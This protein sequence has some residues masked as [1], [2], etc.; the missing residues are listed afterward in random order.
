MLIILP[1]S[2]TKAAGGSGSPLDLDALSFPELRATRRSL[3]D[4]LGGLS[5]AET[6]QALGLSER[7]RD[8]AESNAH[9]EDSPTT[10]AINRYTGVLYDALDAP[11]LPDTSRLVVCSALFGLVRAA[12][13]IPRYRLSAGSK[14]E[15]QTMKRHWGTQL[16]TALDLP[17]LVVDLRSGAYQQ[18]GKVRSAVTARVIDAQTGKVVSHFNKLHKGRL[19]RALAPLDLESADQVADAA[20]SAGFD[21]SLAGTTLTVRV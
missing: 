8:E 15:G 5:T 13:P 12:D 21:V 11:T 14:L 7:Q 6:M 17:E 16:S 1:P 18:L 10:P 2:E 19:A 9:V 20:A 3:L 4:I